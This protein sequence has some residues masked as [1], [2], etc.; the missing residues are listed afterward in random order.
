MT[1]YEPARTAE[2]RR[3]DVT[4][5]LEN[6]EDMWVATSSGAGEPVLVPLSF[7][8]DQG[9]VLMSTK[10]TNPTARNLTPRGEVRLSLGHTR[11]VVLV[12]GVAEAVEAAD[13][14]RSSTDAFADKLG[15]DPRQLPAWVYLRVTPRRI[16]AWR[17]SNEIPGREVMRD[18]VWLV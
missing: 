15:W 14:A 6:D 10:R 5:R 12:E 4:H 7:L 3:R 2:Q 11:D 17:E 13:L 1:E 8:W 9:T 18:G 16:K